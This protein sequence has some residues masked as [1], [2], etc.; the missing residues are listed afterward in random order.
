M[1]C[2]LTLHSVYDE[3]ARALGPEFIGENAPAG[4]DRNTDHDERV[5]IEYRDENLDALLDRTQQAMINIGIPAYQ[6]GGRV[7]YPYRLPCFTAHRHI[8]M[9]EGTLVIER[10][11]A[12]GVRIWMTRAARF[13][14]PNAKGDLRPGAPPLEFANAFLAWKPEWRFPVLRGISDTPV[15]RADGTVCDKEGYDQQSMMLLDF[16]GQVYPA[17]PEQPSREDA[18]R[19]SSGSGRCDLWIS[20]RRQLR[21]AGEVPQP[22]RGAVA[23]PEYP[24]EPDHRRG[25]TPHVHRA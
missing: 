18:A 4:F 12:H 5:T 6:R 16:G 7:V 25:A 21:R 20:V 15:L 9:Q 8:K 3:L 22:K 1:E 10:A 24:G 13:L 19:G 14:T 23:V 17:V 11:V 2:K